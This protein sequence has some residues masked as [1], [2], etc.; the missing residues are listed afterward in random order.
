MASNK[1][2]EHGPE[3]K[4]THSVQ[5]ASLVT[6]TR[7]AYRLSDNDNELAV[8][9]GDNDRIVGFPD[10][11]TT[12][13]D[14]WFNLRKIQVGSVKAVAEEAIA[15]NNQPVT[16]GSTGKIRAAVIG[17]DLVQFYNNSTTA[18]DGDQIEL[19]RS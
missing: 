9:C 5:C 3:P 7:L 11:I 2:K 6:D 16:A 15:T 18:A 19:S 17:T 12:A 10:R 4:E 14:Q 13:T 8:L 1:T